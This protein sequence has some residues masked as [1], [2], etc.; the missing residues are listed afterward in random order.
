[1]KIAELLFETTAV[2][3]GVEQLGDTSNMFEDAAL[4]RLDRVGDDHGDIIAV[5]VADADILTLHGS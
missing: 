1:M 3:L 5:Q 4:G 2:L